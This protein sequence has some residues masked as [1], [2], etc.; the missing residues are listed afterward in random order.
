MMR[1][2]TGA[3]CQN[4]CRRNAISPCW[5]IAVGR[6]IDSGGERKASVER[7]FRLLTRENVPVSS[8]DLLRGGP[9]VV[10]FH[11]AA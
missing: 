3:G 1:A 6:E 8:G 4:S 11:R 9:F 7:V 5:P 10:T 2:A